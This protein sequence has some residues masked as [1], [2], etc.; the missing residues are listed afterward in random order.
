MEF[1]LTS[2]FYIFRISHRRYMDINSMQQARVIAQASTCY[3]LSFQTPLLSNPARYVRTSISI[4]LN[5]PYMIPNSGPPDQNSL[6]HL[7]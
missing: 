4:A 1:E 6:A 5:F 7:Y 3:L 2:V